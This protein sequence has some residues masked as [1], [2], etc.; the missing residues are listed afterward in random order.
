MKQTDRRL[1]HLIPHTSYLI[2][3]RKTACRFTLIELLVVIAII[4]ILA[5]MLMPALQQ[6]RERGRSAQCMS[7]LKQLGLA[8]MSYSRDHGGFIVK[9][10]NLN[11]GKA[12]EGITSEWTG[13]FKF[14][15]YVN[16][17]VFICP[18]LS[19]ASS[20][21]QTNYVANS[22]NVSYP[23]YG[24]SYENYGSGRYR[25]G[26]D[27]GLSIAWS[28]LHSSDIKYPSMMYA[29][30][31]ARQ[32]YAFNGGH[33][34]CHRFSYSFSTSATKRMGNPDGERHGGRIQILFADGHAAT[35]EVDSYDPYKTLGSG[36][37][38]VQWN[39]WSN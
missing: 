17:N 23:G 27:T 2:P 6:A 9:Y 29:I 30:M 5:S 8:C 12:S 39:G 24:I 25:R 26:V 10:M 28:A 20:Y 34:G 16:H 32:T 15:K 11:I 38:L 36:R 18:S 1:S 7:N 37:F 31:D 33:F 13:Y 4:A 19:P 21:A 22:Y 14:A 3:E 35:R